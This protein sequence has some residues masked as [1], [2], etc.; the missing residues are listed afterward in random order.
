MP[1]HRTRVTLASADREG[2]RRNRTRSNPR[3]VVYEGD[4]IP[5]DYLRRMQEHRQ[6]RQEVAHAQ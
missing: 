6:L 3:L 2:S 5:T 1:A 4:A